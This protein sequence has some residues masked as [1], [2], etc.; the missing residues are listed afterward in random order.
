MYMDR[1]QRN[2]DNRERMS[3]PYITHKVKKVKP[4]GDYFTQIFIVLC[5]I[6]LYSLIYW[7][8]ISGEEKN[9]GFKEATNSLERFSALQTIS[10]LVIILLMVGERMLYRSRYIDHRDYEGKYQTAPRQN[11]PKIVR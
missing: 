6:F 10:L 9:Q 5:I 4:G 2:L 7:K 8:N 1:K 11:N 3:N